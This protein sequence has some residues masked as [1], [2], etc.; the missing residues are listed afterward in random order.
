LFYYIDIYNFSS[1]NQ[2]AFT[3]VFSTN[4]GSSYLNTGYYQEG[5]CAS[6]TGYFGN[7]T[8]NGASILLTNTPNAN[9]GFNGIGGFNLCFTSGNQQSILGNMYDGFANW[10]VGGL[11][12]GTTVVNAIR[13]DIAAGTFSGNFKLYGVQN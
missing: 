3:L 6:N 2:V 1:T 8:I 11:N 12:T 13:F 10:A 9:A 5:P 7:S 4:A